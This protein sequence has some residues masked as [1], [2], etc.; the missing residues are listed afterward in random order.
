MEHSVSSVVVLLMTGRLR[1]GWPARRTLWGGVAAALVIL[2]AGTAA[3]M[4]FGHTPAG[5]LAGSPSC[6]RAVNR[7]LHYDPH[8]PDCLWQ[9]YSKGVAADVIM[10]DYT[11]EGDPVTY[12]VAVSATQIQVSIQSQDRYGSQGSF[13]YA[14]Q[15]MARQP[16]A[17]LPG[18]FYLIV[19]GC[20]G[21]PDFLDGSR[22]TLP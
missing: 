20:S 5:R 13:S 1:R 18:R 2:V 3:W 4:I 9:A 21:A 8:P 12:A 7:G 19:T 10:V 14:C 11:L 17:Q 6:G 22:L 16:A 15:A